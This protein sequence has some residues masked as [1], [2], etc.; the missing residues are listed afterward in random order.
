MGNIHYQ[1]K[2]NKAMSVGYEHGRQRVK[3]GCPYKP[4]SQEAQLYKQSWNEGF[5]DQLYFEG[6][7]YDGI[8]ESQS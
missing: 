8:A 7:E 2:L 1:D 6:E 4:G 3:N 5:N